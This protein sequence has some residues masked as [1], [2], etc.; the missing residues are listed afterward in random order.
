VPV[1]ADVY[2][3]APRSVKA[4]RKTTLRAYVA[5]VQTA[6]GKVQFQYYEAKRKRWRTIGTATLSPAGDV[7]S[8]SIRWKPAKGSWK[9][10]AIYT[11]GPTNTSSVSGSRT[12]KAR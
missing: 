6:G 7:A 3:S 12:V 5:P 1:S 4:K 11:G 9:V 10:R 2:L 8:A